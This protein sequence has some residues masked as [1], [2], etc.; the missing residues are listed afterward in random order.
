MKVSVRASESNNTL[1]SVNLSIH[2]SAVKEVKESLDLD[3]TTM[4]GEGCE[5]LTTRVS[6]VSMIFIFRFLSRLATF[7][8]FLASIPIFA[9]FCLLLASFHF[10][11]HI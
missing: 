8:V 2:D 6:A 5:I 1:S 10:K 11:F 7:R 9:S 4:I 3:Q